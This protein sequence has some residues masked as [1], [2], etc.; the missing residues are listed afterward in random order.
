MGK[1]LLKIITPLIFLLLLF[2]NI[3]FAQESKKFAV[4]FTGIGCPHCAKVSPILHKK[5]DE[6]DLI[7]IEY[8]IYNKVAN[9]QVLSTYADKYNLNLGIP[10]VFFS[11]SLKEEGDSPII[12]NLD[13][14]VLNSNPDELYLQD[15]NPILFS[16][17]NLNTLSRYPKIFSKN[18]VAIRESLTTLT[19]EENKQIKEYIYI[20]EIESAIEGLEGKDVEPKPIKTPSST[21]NY[22]HALKINGWL[23]QWNGASLKKVS[24][25]EGSVNINE[26]DSS[27]ELSLGNL[28]SLGLA[29]SINPCALSILALVL[30]SI[31]TY[32]PGKRKDIL[33][34]GL[35]FVLSVF[36]MYLLYGVLIVKAFSVVQSIGNIRA[37][38]FGKLGL[39]FILGIIAIILGILGLKDFISYKPGSIG[40]EMPMFLRPKVN[41]LVAKVTSPIAAFGIGLFVT[42]FLLPCTIGPYIIVGGLLSTDGVIKAIPSL[43]LYNLIFIIPM[44]SVTLLVYFGTRKVEDIKDWKDKNVRY[45][46]LVSGILLLVIGVLMLL[47]KF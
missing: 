45:M 20:S 46:H 43:L 3:S 35:A 36:I 37:F 4:Y 1:K 27:E 39:N 14:L 31:I 21:L 29:D 23:L 47:G 24:T 25:S 41:K 34:A 32:N 38:L 17:L 8:E 30:I 12:N 26:V 7:V 33:L 44:L 22:E 16:D 15:G 19:D 5:I 28:I 11:P 40:T 13:N 9:S 42:I 6:G 10:Q 2:V 18:R